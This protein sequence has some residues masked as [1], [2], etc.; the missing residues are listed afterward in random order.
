MRAEL[1]LRAAPRAPH[2]AHAGEAVGRRRD[3]GVAHLEAV[4][5]ASGSHVAFAATWR[6]KRWPPK[7]RSGNRCGVGKVMA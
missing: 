2:H 5:P 1:C 3:A 7:S 4:A 6:T